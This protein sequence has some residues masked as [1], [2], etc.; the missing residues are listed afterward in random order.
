[1]T[2]GTVGW[3]LGMPLPVVTVL[4]PVRELVETRCTDPRGAR[5]RSPRPTPMENG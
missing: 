1:M 2:L 3:T 4:L 5:R